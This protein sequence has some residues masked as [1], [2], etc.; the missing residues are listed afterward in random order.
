[1]DPHHCSKK[2]DMISAPLPGE[3]CEVE[4]DLI[5]SGSYVR[6]RLFLHIQHDL[7]AWGSVIRKTEKLFVKFSIQHRN[8]K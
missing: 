3:R 4:T 5:Y 7:F 6:N 1:M 2:I 8:K